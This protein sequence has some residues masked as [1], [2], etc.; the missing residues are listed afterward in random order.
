MRP[1]LTLL[2][3]GSLLPAQGLDAA[4]VR[5]LLKRMDQA[6]NQG[7]FQAYAD[8]LA[9]G[10]HP[11]LRAEHLA[12]IRQLLELDK[13]PRMQSQ[14]LRVKRQ[15]PHGAALISRTLG[16]GR[17]QMQVD[18]YLGLQHHEG[19]LRGL[20]YVPV[21]A[22]AA[23]LHCRS[24][25]YSCPACNYSISHGP[26]WLSVPQS[27]RRT[28]CMEGHKLVSFRHDLVVETAVHIAQRAHPAA[29]ALEHIL[30]T[31]RSLDL[32][33]SARTSP[34]PWKRPDLA[35]KRL[36]TAWART[37][38]AD[39]R[40]AWLHLVC[41]G[42]MQYLLV[43]RGP[44]LARAREDLDKLL[45]GFRLLEPGG[46]PDQLA[47]HALRIHTGGWLDQDNRYHNAKHKL[48]LQGPQGWKGVEMARDSLF[49]LHFEHPAGKGSLH[50]RGLAPDFK[51][52]GEGC[53]DHFRDRLEKQL[54][55]GWSKF[56]PWCD[57]VKGFKMCRAQLHG[58]GTG[59]KRSLVLAARPD[60][61]LVFEADAGDE[62]SWDAIQ[63]A[64]QSLR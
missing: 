63:Q 5:D 62:A 4:T 10:L 45:A 11:S 16:E 30:R 33:R 50:V 13:V 19:Q 32:S 38:S 17:L 25:A 64:I 56:E 8:L 20:F 59:R 46:D 9:P 24:E 37:Q 21:D 51:A 48:G 12:E 23:K 7:R 49:E 40:E 54:D 26:D 41:H 39:A 36:S 2:L 58:P 29:R 3:T 1:G 35:G 31:C 28:G 22:K 27:A 61:L 6:F 52:W 14:L 60:V 18:A 42:R 44:A 15:G 34:Q 57:G 53:C 55:A 43:A 47:A